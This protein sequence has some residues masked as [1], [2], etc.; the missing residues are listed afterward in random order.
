MK[1]VYLTYLLPLVLATGCSTIR[2]KTMPDE[3]NLLSGSGSL[4]V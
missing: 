3:A 1:T 2:E 4:L